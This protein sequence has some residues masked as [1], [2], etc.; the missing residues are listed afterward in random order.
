MSLAFLRSFYDKHIRARD[1]AAAAASAP[2]TTTDFVAKQPVMLHTWSTTATTTPSSNSGGSA[3]DGRG[4]RY[5][6]LLAPEQRWPG[7]ASGKDMFFVSHAFGNPFRLLLD[8]LE[9]HFK[10]AGATAESAFI[11]LGAPAGSGAT[12]ASPPL[13]PARKIVHRCCWRLH[14]FP[15]WLRS[16]V[17]SI[18][19][20]FRPFF[21]S[22]DI[23]AINQ[24]DP[25]VDLDQGRT[26]AVRT[27]T[28][29]DTI[30]RRREKE[31]GTSGVA[32]CR[33]NTVVCPRV[34]LL[35]A[36]KQ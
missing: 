19:F 34:P 31:R 21:S 14:D 1:V 5:V 12:T 22:A 28:F 3:D 33:Q 29:A 36:A 30:R 6:D 9:A 17:F 20:I 11:W 27:D 25:G 23:F 7:P 13:L 4:R 16:P 2:L 32:C 24:H 10:A 15:S 26:L 18:F 35:L 8:T